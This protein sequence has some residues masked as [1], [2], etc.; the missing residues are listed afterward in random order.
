MAKSAENA[1][2]TVQKYYPN[3]LELL[4]ISKL[5][6]RFYS[7]E[8]LSF[9]Q[10]RELDSK[11]SPKEKTQHFL[12]T[13]LI[14]GLNVDYNGHFDEMIIMMKNSDD[15]L[16]K[17]LSEKLIADVSAKDLAVSTK[18]TS[19]ALL[20]TDAGNYRGL[21]NMRLCCLVYCCMCIANWALTGGLWKF[22]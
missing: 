9:D 12:D 4:P 20:P 19:R 21:N 16:A 11:T 8:L 13:I 3:L 15:V 7:R 5:V 22:L 6:E 17:R 18:D 2:S 10:K 14:P 1:R